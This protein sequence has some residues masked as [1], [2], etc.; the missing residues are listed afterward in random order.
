M[1]FSQQIKGELI[2]ITSQARH[3]QIAEVATLIAYK[4][5]VK[6]KK[7]GQFIIEI[8]S[9]EK[10]IIRKYFTLFKKTYNIVSDV[11]EEADFYR[12]QV[13]NQE[14]IFQILKSVKFMKDDE[15]DVSATLSSLLFKSTCCKR[16]FLRNVFYINGSMSDPEKAYHLEFVCDALCQ[17]EQIRE[18]LKDFEIQSGIINRKKNYITYI[19]DGTSIVELLNIIGA[20]NSLM[21]LENLRIIKEVKNT[22]NRRVNCET[23]NIAKTVGAASK[24]I[25]DIKK[26]IKY[27]EM[28]N[29]PMNLQ[30]MAM[31]RLDNPDISL[32]ELGRLLEP[33]L[34]KSGVNHR[35][36]KICEFADK[37]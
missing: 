7:D 8:T 18:V 19:K 37:L 13:V 30:E 1:S 6:R 36:R 10:T 27:R 11:V 12:M 35:L 28:K 21:E 5:I 32:S 20:H 4:N 22:V 15:I 23:A 3:C 29:L 17:A 16:A 33:P 34:G 9:D 25:D 2:Y 26:I 31:V 24:Q 14:D